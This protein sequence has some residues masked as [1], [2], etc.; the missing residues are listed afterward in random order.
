METTKN[1]Y[2]NNNCNTVYTVNWGLS[3]SVLPPSLV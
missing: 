1:I 3:Y 2:S